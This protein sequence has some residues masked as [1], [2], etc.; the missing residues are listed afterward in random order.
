[1]SI[2]THLNRTLRR[3]ERPY[4][5][6]NR[7]EVSGSSLRHNIAFFRSKTGL[8][9]LPVLKGNAYGHGIEQVATA[10][11]SERFPYIAVDGYFEALT[12][13]S[14]NRH[15]PVLVMGMIK[16]SNFAKL[17]LRGLAFVVQDKA[18]I[19][20]MGDLSKNINIH[21]E[22]NTGMNRYGVKL[23][24]L[25]QYIQLIQNF[26]KLQLEG[27]M[28]HLADPD[29]KNEA[30]IHKAV[31]QFDQ[32]VEKILAS[33]L[34]PT[35][36]HTAQSGGGLRA[37]SRYANAMRLGIG[38]YGINPYPA[39]HPLHA[40]MD[41]R[42]AM[43]LISTITKVQELQKGEKVSYNYTFTAP[44][45]MRIGILPMGYHEGVSRDL[46]NKG[47][48]KTGSRFQPIVGRVCMN[49]TLLNLEGTNVQAGDEVVV[50]SSRRQDKNSIDSVA[51]AYGL[52]SYGLLAGLS[53]DVRRILT[54]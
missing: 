9:I 10:I 29:G 13:R 25:D 17:K 3:L 38:L 21:L 43:T 53:P 8:Q 5:V 24:E 39:D 28:T 33:G 46:S 4:D 12:V 51:E 18:T 16:P 50:Y 30:T 47:V 2:R 32:A 14:F 52:F 37:K 7:I 45:A 20:A 15:Q 6:Y 1:M 49:H 11:K 19:R 26:P 42:P 35:L 36:F 40:K 27:V 34:K 44:H 23:S 48:V 31:T 54:K 22:L 41:L